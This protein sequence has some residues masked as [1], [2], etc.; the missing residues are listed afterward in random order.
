VP[1]QSSALVGRLVDSAGEPVAG[2]RIEVRSGR[3]PNRLWPIARSGPDGAF[4][5]A[6]L[7]DDSYRV[8][9]RAGDARVQ[10]GLIVPRGYEQTVEIPPL[11]LRADD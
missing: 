11:D 2:A 8:D 3:H 10:L 1:G 9:V 7:V 4:R 6:H 5:V